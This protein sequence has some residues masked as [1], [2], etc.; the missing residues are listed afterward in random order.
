[1]TQLVDVRRWNT[2]RFLILLFQV[3]NKKVQRLL[4]YDFCVLTCNQPDFHGLYQ[5]NEINLSILSNNITKAI[6]NIV[7][8]SEL[9]QFYNKKYH[10]LSSNLRYRVINKFWNDLVKKIEEILPHGSFC[11]KDMTSINGVISEVPWYRFLKTSTS[12]YAHFSL[13]ACFLSQCQDIWVR[14]LSGGE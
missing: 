4:I 12:T 3:N 13:F 6:I 14:V 7:F 8:L 2:A 5:L 11:F 1:M 9:K 10:S